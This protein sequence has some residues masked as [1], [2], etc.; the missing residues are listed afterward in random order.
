AHTA[1]ENVGFMKCF[2]KGVVDRD[3][4]AKFLGNL[5]YVYSELEAALEHHKD[6]S[7]ISVVYFREL[8]RK[9]NLEKD[10]EFY[11]GQDWRGKIAPSKAAQIYIARIHEISAKEPALL[12]GHA[13]TRYMGD[14]SGGQMLQKVAQ[15]VLKLSG[16]EGTSFYNFEQVPDKKAFKDKY[17]QVLDSLPIDDATADKIVAE[18]NNAFQLNMQMVQEL[19]QILIKAIG[20]AMFNTLTNTN[21]TDSTELSTA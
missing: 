10:L 17:R 1:A 19:E 14:L 9:A 6:H 21:N 4:F 15:S 13:Y 5:Y 7:L 18:A 3:C 11:Y 12:I 8:N 20:Q 2:V 16:Y